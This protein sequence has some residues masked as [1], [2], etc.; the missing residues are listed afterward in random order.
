MAAITEKLDELIAE[1][2]QDIVDTKQKLMQ[3]EA[4]LSGFESA[5]IAVVET[6]QSKR[7]TEPENGFRSLSIAWVQVLSFIGG[8]R[9]VGATLDEIN[10]FVTESDLGIRRETIRSQLS[11]YNKKQILKRIGS[12]IYQL[13]AIGMQA[14][15]NSQSTT[16]EASDTT[17]AARQLSELQAAVE[18]LVEIGTA[19][20]SLTSLTDSL[21]DKLRNQRDASSLLA[22]ERVAIALARSKAE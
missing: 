9:E 18:S 1:C 17:S 16:I 6:L 13:T 4:K 10:R 5:R 11:I 7:K 8:K 15:K 22:S 2:E 21:A 3:L 12:S 19:E 20:K 14:I